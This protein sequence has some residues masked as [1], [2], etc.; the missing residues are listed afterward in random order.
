MFSWGRVL[1]LIQVE[2]LVHLFDLMPLTSASLPLLL[3]NPTDPHTG[4]QAVKLSAEV[5]GCLLRKQH[6]VELIHGAFLHLNVVT[7]PLTA[8]LTVTGR[9]ML[10]S[11]FRVRF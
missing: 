5:A 2:V 6:P 10:G 7:L 3:T 9:V 11:Y 4:L 1:P 8:N